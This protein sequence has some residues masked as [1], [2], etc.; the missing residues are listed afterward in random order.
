MEYSLADYIN[1]KH[2]APHVRACLT[3]DANDKYD[4]YLSEAGVEIMQTTTA[5]TQGQI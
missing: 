5:A 1:V 4:Y 3:S 2:P